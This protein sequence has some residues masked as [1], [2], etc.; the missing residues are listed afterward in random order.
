[1]FVSTHLI[2]ELEGIVDDVTLLAEGRVVASL[3]ADAAR[4]RYRLLR[5]SFEDSTCP[6]KHSA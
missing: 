1:M 4:G 3:G 5:A 6:Q 2:S